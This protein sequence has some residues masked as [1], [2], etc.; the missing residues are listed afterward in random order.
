MLPLGALIENKILCVSSGI[1]KNIQTLDDIE[2]IERPISN[3]WDI[4]NLNNSLAHEI[5][6][7][8]YTE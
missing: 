8:Q 1:G 4:N 7:T 2:N 3:L 5:L 6:W